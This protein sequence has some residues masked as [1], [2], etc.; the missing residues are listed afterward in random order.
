MNGLSETAARASKRMDELEKSRELSISLSRALIRKTKRMI[1]AVHEG[2][3]HTALRNELSVDMSSMLAQLKDEP[4]LLYSGPVDDAMMEYSEACLLASVVDG[5]AM[6]SFE[7]LGITPGSWMMGLAD[8]VGELRR[9]VLSCLMRGD[10]DNAKIY[11]EAMD[12]MSNEVMM[13]DVPD[14]VLPIRHKQDSTR[15]IMEKT[16]SDM[17]GAVMMDGLKNRIKK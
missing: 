15:G 11:F 5:I 8:C 3:D 14:A 16:R 10:I 7:E 9:L 6:P 1:H 4:E 13:F 2:E 12:E 17:T